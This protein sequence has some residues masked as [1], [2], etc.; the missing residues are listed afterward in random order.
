MTLEF[1]KNNYSD[2]S[3]LGIVDSDWACGT[4][5]RKSL[6]G[7]TFKVFESIQNIVV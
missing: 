7:L 3:L 2:V 4:E 1:K 6:S 5:G